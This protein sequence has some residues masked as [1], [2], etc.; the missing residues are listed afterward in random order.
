M[1]QLIVIAELSPQ[2][3]AAVATVRPSIGGD[4]HLVPV[5][6]VPRPYY[7]AN[8]PLLS[9]IS[10]DPV[11]RLRLLILLLWIQRFDILTR[12]LD[13]RVWIV[14]RYAMAA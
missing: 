8:G 1:R 13:G 7:A 5:V 6:S 3:D 12:N 11:C 4:S 2:L 9:A 10:H 14:L